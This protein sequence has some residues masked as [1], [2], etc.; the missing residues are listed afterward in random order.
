M[1]FSPLNCVVVNYPLSGI[2][3]HF[4]RYTQNSAVYA[5]DSFSRFK[6]PL[7]AVIKASVVSPVPVLR[8]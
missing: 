4:C 1:L 3:A 2:G 8:E 5:S 6:G 7:G